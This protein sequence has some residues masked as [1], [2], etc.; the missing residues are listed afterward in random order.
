MPWAPTDSSGLAQLTAAIQSL[1]LCPSNDL[2]VHLVVP[3]DPC[4]GCDTA[5]SILELSWRG[6]LADQWRSLL[7]NVEFVRH[8]R[9]ASSLEVST[10]CII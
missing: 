9:G 3:H 6:R 1:V 7:K 10:H 2:T 5:E 4:P 8:P